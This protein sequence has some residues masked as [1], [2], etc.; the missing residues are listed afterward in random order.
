MWICT[1]PAFVVSRF[2]ICKHLIQLVLKV[3][4]KFF[5]EAE[6]YR[7]A[8]FWRHPELQP[9]VGHEPDA[10]RDFSSL[11]EGFEQLEVDKEV[12]YNHEDDDLIQTQVIEDPEFEPETSFEAKIANHVEL[13]RQFA[14]GIEYQSRFR[15]RRFLDA[16]WKEGRSF[17]RMAKN[18]LEVERQESTNRREKKTTW[19]MGTVTFYHPCPCL[20]NM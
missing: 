15:D 17:F 4:P 8:P 9:A 2:L 11:L 18:C 1:C 10:D 7:T 3:P 13:L 12:S 5:I 16:L 14:A 20:S 6:R 19:A